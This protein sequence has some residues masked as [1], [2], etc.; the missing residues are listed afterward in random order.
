MLFKLG[1]AQRRVVAGFS[2]DVAKGLILASILGQGTIERLPVV[3][4]FLI[5]FVWV[6]LG[7]LLLYFAIRFTPYERN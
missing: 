1:S 7:L 6:G 4:R 3:Q 5:S 2:S